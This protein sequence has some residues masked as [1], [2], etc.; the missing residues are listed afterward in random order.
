MA[1]K[2][3]K[4]PVVSYEHWR[5]IQNQHFAQS[6]K[7]REKS[8]GTFKQLI[9]VEDEE[10]RFIERNEL[11]VTLEHW[12]STW[13]KKQKVFAITGEEGDGKTWGVAHW[14]SQQIQL[15]DVY[16][17]VIF[18]SSIQFTTNKI[19]SLLDENIPVKFDNLTVEEYLEEIARWIAKSDNNTP[20]FLKEKYVILLV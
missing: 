15:H 18:L 14:L 19:I 10:V 7:S 6:L 8:L 3:T 4:K 1:A 16:P 17:A 11:K 2:I 20:P 13:Q 9:N 12:Y 5:V